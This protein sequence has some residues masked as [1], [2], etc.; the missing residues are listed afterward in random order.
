[1]NK[2]LEKIAEMLE[3][4]KKGEKKQPVTEPNQVAKPLDK[5]DS[6]EE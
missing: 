6:E 2:Y 3:N 1:M 5:E 4:K